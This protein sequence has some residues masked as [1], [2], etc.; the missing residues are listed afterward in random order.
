MTGRIGDWIQTFTGKRFYPLDPREED[1]DI[2]DI[3]HALS[4]Q[5]RYA[6]HCLRFYS[7]AEHSVLL[8]RFLRP[9]GR[10]LARW[11]LL[12]DAS[13][14]YILDV[15]R[16]L[17]PFLTNYRGIEATIMDMVAKRFGL[18][19][20]MPSELKR[21]D[22][23]ILADEVAQNLVPLK[24]DYEPGPRLGVTLKFWTPAEAERAFLEQ[25]ALLE[26]A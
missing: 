1:I 11:A 3:A 24:W 5:C 12:H 13:E 21:A 26:V 15:P 23:R 4:M 17:K 19:S 6:G 10:M 7:V 14:A 9:E 18:Y 22:D 25:F 16:P 2:R 20:A 8:S